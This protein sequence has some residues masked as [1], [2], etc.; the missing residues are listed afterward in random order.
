MASNAAE[1]IAEA[2]RAGA[3][4]AFFGPV[5]SYAIRVQYVQDRIASLPPD[6]IAAANAKAQEW[7]G[8]GGV[9]Y[10]ALRVPDSGGLTKAVKAIPAIGKPLASVTSKASEILSKTPVI[11]PAVERAENNELAKKVA[12]IGVSVV[13]PTAIFAKAADI[14]TGGSVVM[15]KLASGSPVVD[16]GAVK[17]YAKGTGDNFLSKAADFAGAGKAVVAGGAAL[18]AGGPGAAAATG[19]ASPAVAGGGSAGSTG[20]LGTVGS[21]VTGIAGTA[22]S[23]LDPLT[24][25]FDDVKGGTGPVADYDTPTAERVGGSGMM[26][27]LAAAAAVGVF[28]I[29]RK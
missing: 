12:K 17:L 23:I 16:Y 24:S 5:A 8:V 1:L 21:A 13:G 20:I 14:A 18:F 10:N 26:L 2:D 9:I 25:I 29:A 15:G 27:A 19:G 6:Q 11:A 28:L 4:G 22:L 3:Q 7:A